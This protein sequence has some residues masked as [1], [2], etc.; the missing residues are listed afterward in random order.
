MEVFLYCKS[1]FLICTFIVLF[2]TG[3]VQL[4]KY[5]IVTV[6]YFVVVVD[7]ACDFHLNRIS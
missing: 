2:E 5:F 4:N 6:L 3:S 7:V 1:P